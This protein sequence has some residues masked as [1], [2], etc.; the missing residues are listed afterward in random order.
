MISLVVVDE[1]IGESVELRNVPYLRETIAANEHEVRRANSL[2]K[3]ATVTEEES[4]V[5][6]GGIEVLTGGGGLSS[7]VSGSA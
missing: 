7:F 4:E 1:T 5:E 2:G 3:A 6:R